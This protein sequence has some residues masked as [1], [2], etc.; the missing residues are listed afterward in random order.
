M[1][2]LGPVFRLSGHSVNRDWCLRTAEGLL[3]RELGWAPAYSLADLAP[4]LAAKCGHPLWYDFEQYVEAAMIR[5]A[6]IR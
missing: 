6:G 2:D 3:V 5:E 1:I 4:R